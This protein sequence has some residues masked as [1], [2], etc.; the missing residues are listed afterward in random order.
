MLGSTKLVQ[1][2]REVCEVDIL[3]GVRDHGEHV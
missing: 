2:G 1:E 3:G